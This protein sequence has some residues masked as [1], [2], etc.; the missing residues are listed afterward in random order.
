MYGRVP[1]DVFFGM[2]CYALKDVVR[3]DAGKEHAGAEWIETMRLLTDLCLEIVC[4]LYCY[5]D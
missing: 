5:D 2:V 3:H 4:K 1:P